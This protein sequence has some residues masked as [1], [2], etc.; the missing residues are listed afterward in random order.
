MPNSY[1]KA[2][3]EPDIDIYFYVP[4]GMIVEEEELQNLIV[5]RI[6]EVVLQL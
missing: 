3:P 5:Q 1:V 4:Q 2:P 6:V